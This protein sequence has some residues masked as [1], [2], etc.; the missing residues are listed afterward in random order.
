[1]EKL[2]VSS[3][4]RINKEGIMNSPFVL[5]YEKHPNKVIVRAKEIRRLCREISRDPVQHYA[6][7]R[8]ME[9]KMVNMDAMSCRA[10]YNNL[11][12]QFRSCC[13]TW[14]HYSGSPSYPIKAFLTYADAVEEFRY[15]QNYWQGNS[16]RHRRS[17]LHHFAKNAQ[18]IEIDFN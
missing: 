9:I 11:I 8:N 15:V 2:L 3:Y 1:V 12:Q 14:P 18:D 6:I 13:K 16:G 4:N 10:I 5:K 17:L 7:C